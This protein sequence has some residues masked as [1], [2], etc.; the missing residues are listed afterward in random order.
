MFMSLQY[1]F[2]ESLIPLSR[3]LFGSELW[4]EDNSSTEN[5]RTSCDCQDQHSFSSFVLE[6]KGKLLEGGMESQIQI[7]YETQLDT[8]LTSK[9][10]GKL[11]SLSESQQAYVKDRIK[12]TLELSKQEYES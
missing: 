12:K 7:Q 11:Q 6:N 8:I 3:S 1:P 2:F 10:G 5:E 4:S 9:G